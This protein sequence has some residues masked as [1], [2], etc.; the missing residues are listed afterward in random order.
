MNIAKHHALR[1]AVLFAVLLAAVF[2]HDA[3]LLNDLFVVRQCRAA[4]LRAFVQQSD[5]FASRRADFNVNVREQRQESRQASGKPTRKRAQLIRINIQRLS[6]S[7]LSAYLS[8][9]S[10]LTKSSSDKEDASSPHASS[11]TEQ[12]LPTIFASKY[13]SKSVINDSA[14][15]SSTLQTKQIS[16]S[17]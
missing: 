11:A 15:S 7:A 9:Y 16:A 10:S 6:L 14:F 5:V 13:F 4:F 1:F 8:T 17:A 3:E 12:M 2:A